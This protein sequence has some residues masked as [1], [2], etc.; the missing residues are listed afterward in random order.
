MMTVRRIATNPPRVCIVELLPGGT[1]R[2]DRLAIPLE[3][4]RRIAA[5]LIT[6]ANELDKES[7]P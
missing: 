5:E 1:L 4:V 7:R 6:V 2:H 3:D